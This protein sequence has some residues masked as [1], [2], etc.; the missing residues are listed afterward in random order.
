MSALSRKIR[1]GGL[2][3]ADGERIA[4]LFDQHVENGLYRRIPVSEQHYIAAQAWLRGFNTSLRSLD[5][6][7]LAVAG[8]ANLQLVTADKIL[9][10]SATTLGIATQF[11][12]VQ[13]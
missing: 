1:E 13:D 4:A 7:H 10:S 9:A 2:P 3:M 12:S 11:L 8:S 5:A 6:I